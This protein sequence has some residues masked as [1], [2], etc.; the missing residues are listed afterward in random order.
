MEILGNLLIY[1]V[2]IGF[3]VLGAY[4]LGLFLVFDSKSTFFSNFG[5]IIKKWRKSLLYKSESSI[6]LF[7]E[8]NF[9]GSSHE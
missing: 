4:S 6:M 5:K 3:S 7:V 1:V 2:C 9:K 8:V